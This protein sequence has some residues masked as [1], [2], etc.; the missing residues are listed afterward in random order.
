[1]NICPANC[2]N[3]E[4][5]AN[6]VTGVCDAAETRERG[7]YKLGFYLC[8]TPLPS[9]LTCTA[10]NTLVTS[11]AVVFSSPL[12]NVTFGEPEFEDIKMND[13]EPAIQRIVGRTLTFNDKYKVTIPGI[14]AEGE[15]PAVPENRYGDLLFWGNKMEARLSMRVIIL[16]CDGTMEVPKDKNG[17]PLSSTF[18]VYRD[19]ERQGTGTNETIIEV[20]RGTIRFKGDPLQFREPD[21]DLNDAMCDDLANAIGFNI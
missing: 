15:T 7:I 13:C 2:A 14:P 3:I 9:P 1:M 16:Y 17:N 19:F 12:S 6:P 20:K 21:L 5:I 4:L 10:L 11:G 18:L 8:N